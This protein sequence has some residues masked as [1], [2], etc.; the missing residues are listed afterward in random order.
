M[1][2]LVTKSPVPW[3]GGKSRMAK[4]II[5][6][7]PRHTIY[8]EPF[9]GGGWVLFGKQP[10]AV[11]VYNDLDHGLVNFFRV[12]RDPDKASKLFFN[13]TLSPYSR[14]EHTDCKAEWEDSDCPIEMAR[15]W[16][17]VARQSFAAMFDGSWGASKS[18]TGGMSQQASSWLGGI[19]ILSA[20]HL[21]LMRVLIEN[22]DY[23]RLMPRFDT[24]DTLFY[25]DPPY[26]PET[27]RNGGYRCEMST[28]DHTELVGML[29]ELKG[30]V[31]LSGYE[32]AVYKPLIKSGWK[33]KR[34]TMT[35]SAAGRTRTSG[36]QGKGNV[37][38]KQKRTE[39]LYLSPRLLSALD[40]EKHDG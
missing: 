2:S 1:K 39:C 25:C 22:Q 20:A 28:E 23:R 32:S 19:S 29:L 37:S 10:S 36:L 12:L 27:R 5:E 18:S 14:T 40:E 13:L 17:V 6:H 9:G 35:C 33:R 8:V 16:M 4:T 38:A 34:Y 24:G 21:R 30:M 7:F 31:I 11:E 3:F 15:S 26:V